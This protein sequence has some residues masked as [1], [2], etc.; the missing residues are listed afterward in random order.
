M[1]IAGLG[2][3]VVKERMEGG[4][5]WGAWLIVSSFLLDTKQHLSFCAVSVLLAIFLLSS[6]YYYHYVKSCRHNRRVPPGSLGVPLIGETLQFAFYNTCPIGSPPPFLSS[7]L[8]KYGTIFKTH[9]MGYPTVISMDLELNKLLLS[10]EE[11][12]VQANFPSFIKKIAGPLLTVHGA[13]HKRFQE[14]ATSAFNPA[15]IQAHHLIPVQEFMCSILHPWLHMPIVDAQHECRKFTFTYIVK[16][17]VSLA[18]EDPKTELLMRNYL[19]LGI[20]FSAIM[21]VDLPGTTYNKVLKARKRIITIFSSLVQARRKIVEVECKDFLDMVIKEKDECGK[22]FSDQ[23]IVEFIFFLVIGGFETT[24][25]LLTNVM[26]FL[27]ENAHVVNELRKEHT[28]IRNN[29]KANEILAWDDFKKMQFTQLVIK[30]TLRMAS[31]AH[32]VS[33]KALQ[34][35]VFKDMV[36]PKGWKIMINFS[37]VHL[38]P[39]HCKNPLKYDPWRWKDTERSSQAFLMPFSGGKRS[40]PGSFLVKFQASIFIHYLVTRYKWERKM[41][42]DGQLDVV[43][44]LSLPTMRNGL[45]IKVEPL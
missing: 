45:F 42:V 21:P 3:V 43:S 15:A 16:S 33:R 26:K 31:I 24:S 8:R 2:L 4:G 35:I 5:D 11:K 17:L 29:K 25:I 7:R 22:H 38:S 41:D 27:S 13:C 19:L 36:I 32:Y 14:L 28:F 44:S 20:G 1:R 12:L 34:D 6:S 10:N 23:E 39:S 9:L 18:P 30:E 40:C 37:M